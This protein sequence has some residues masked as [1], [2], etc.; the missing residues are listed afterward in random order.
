MAIPFAVLLLGLVSQFVSHPLPSS[1][2]NGGGAYR[3]FL[4]TLIGLSLGGTNVING[5]DYPT[6]LIVAGLC[7]G[8][9]GLRTSG[10]TPPDTSKIRQILTAVV[11][12]GVLVILSRVFFWPFYRYFTPQLSFS[13]IRLVAAAQRTDL[14]YFLIIYGLFLWI[15]LFFTSSRFHWLFT[16]ST[17]ER[18]K[19]IKLVYW[20][21]IVLGSVL[22][23][24]FFSTW[25]LPIAG[26]ISIIFLYLIY[27]EVLFSSPSPNPLRQAQDRLSHQGRRVKEFLLNNQ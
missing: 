1:S 14:G 6:Y 10:V 24:L 25:V 5:W 27:K 18:A 13:N 15:I 23:Y 8:I 17:D 11:M 3:W 2:V 12:I 7:I 21:G 16:S 19:N 20:N 26:L 9:A 22:G 4:L